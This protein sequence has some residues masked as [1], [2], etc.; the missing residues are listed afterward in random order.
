MEPDLA[1][2]AEF[3][4]AWRNLLSF[5]GWTATQV[6]R[7][8]DGVVA[9]SSTIP[10]FYNQPPAFWLARSLIPGDLAALPPPDDQALWQD[11]FCVLESRGHWNDF[12]DAVTCKIIS[13][14]LD[15]VFHRWRGRLRQS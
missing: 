9:D 15:D 2:I 3:T 5:R 12:G 10:Q 4:Q 6:D 8:I 13:E 1:A 11:V 7:W 14:S